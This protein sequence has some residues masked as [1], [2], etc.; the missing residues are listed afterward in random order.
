MWL[1]IQIK[2]DKKGRELAKFLRTIEYVESVD[3]ENAL[4]PLKE[5][6]WVKPG[7]PATDEEL[8][9]LAGEMENEEDGMEAKGFFNDLKKKIAG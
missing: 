7:R 6:D 5:E 2:D 9:Q 4:T 3:E 1:S 8:E